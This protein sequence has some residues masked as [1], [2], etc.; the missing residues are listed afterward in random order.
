MARKPHRPRETRGPLQGPSYR[1][2]LFDRDF[3]L[4]P[5]MAQMAAETALNPQATPEMLHDLAA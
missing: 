4:S 2:A 1:L 5:A 3:L